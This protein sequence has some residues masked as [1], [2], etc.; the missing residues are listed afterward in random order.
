MKAEYNPHSIT[1]ARRYIAN[2]RKLLRESAQKEDDLYK[3]TKYVK[4]AG[5]TAYIGVLEAFDTLFAHKSKARKSVD[6]YKLQLV[7]TDKKLL[8]NFNA[9]YASL[10]LAMSYDGNPSVAVAQDGLARAETIIDW[11]ETRLATSGQ[12]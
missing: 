7:K 4:M 11:V 5:H 12:A 9:V 6:W 1:D 10:H 8:D 3:D 2:A